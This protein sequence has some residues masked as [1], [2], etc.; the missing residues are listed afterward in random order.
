MWANKW[1]TICEMP[2]SAAMRSQQIGGGAVYSGMTLKWDYKKYTCD[3]SMPGYVAYLLNKF[4]H[5]TTKI[6]STY[7]PSTS[8]LSMAQKPSTQPEMRHGTYQKSSAPT[9][10][11]SQD[12]FYSKLGQYTL[13]YVCPSMTLSQEKLS[14][15]K[16]TSSDRSVL[17]LPG[18][19]S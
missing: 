9:S 10:K 2:Y 19:T 13:L 5:D 6:L 16:D 17:G 4:Q 15:R 18:Y 3:I 14:H 7:L 8:P 11:I 12:Q 1:H